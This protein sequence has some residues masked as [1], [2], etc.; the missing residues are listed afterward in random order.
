MTCKEVMTTNPVCCLPVDSASRAAK[1]M[2][3][4]NVGSIPICEDR[5]NKKLL[6]IVTDRDLA[7]KVVA[8]GRDASNTRV[9]NIMTQQPVSCHAEDDV[10]KA[11]DAME[12]RQV[13]RIPVVDD[14]NQLIGIIAQADV[15]TRFRQPDKI[16][17]V[18]L[19]ISKPRAA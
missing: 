14:K 3:T 11:I 13:R 4:E 19:E 10:Q 12:S 6:G 7:L 1:L 18:V 16:A 8:E 2:K 17:E 5:Q 15:A 9:Q